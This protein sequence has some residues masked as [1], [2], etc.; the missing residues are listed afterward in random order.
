LEQLAR[1]RRLGCSLLGGEDSSLVWEY[2]QAL[3][4]ASL[5]SHALRFEP[6]GIDSYAFMRLSQEEP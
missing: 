3:E 2:E 5:W 1:L 4:Q 6:A